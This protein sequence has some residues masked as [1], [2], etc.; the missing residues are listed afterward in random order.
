MRREL[1]HTIEHG[2]SCNKTL[3]KWHVSSRLFITNSLTLDGIGF[4]NS[5]LIRAGLHH[6]PWSWT[7]E[8]GLFFHGPTWWS[9]FFGLISL[10]KNI[11]KVFGPLTRCKPNVDQKEERPCT[12]KWMCC[13]FLNIG[14]K[15]AFLDFFFKFDH[16]FVLSCLCLLFPKRKFHWFFIITIFSLHGPLSSFYQS[17]CFASPNAKPVGPCEWI[18]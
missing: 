11:Y 2:H 18:M 8:D 14:P 7:M 17:T 5:K 15:T 4:Q 3:W 1:L 10:K 6:G 12:K 13:L 9:N 16:S